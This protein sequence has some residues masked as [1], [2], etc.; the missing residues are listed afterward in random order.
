MKD[1]RLAGVRKPPE[2]L[3][4]RCG[5]AEEVRKVMKG[6]RRAGVRKPPENLTRRR[7]DAEEVRKVMKGGNGASETSAVTLRRATGVNPWA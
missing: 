2:N 5:D 7:G 3:M 4:R 1:R 6:G